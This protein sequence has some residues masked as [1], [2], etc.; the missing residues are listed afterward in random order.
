MAEDASMAREQVPRGMFLWELCILTRVEGL[1][2]EKLL[3]CFSEVPQ[4][5]N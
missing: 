2:P 4:R 3:I 5:D 1:S